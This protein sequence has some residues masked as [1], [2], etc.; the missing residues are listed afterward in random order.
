MT[1]QPTDPKSTE[2]SPQ[3]NQVFRY[4]AAIAQVRATA[5]VAQLSFGQ[6]G[7]PGAPPDALQD[8]VVS[9]P[10]PLAKVLHQVLGKI[11]EAYEKQEGTISVPNSIAAT[12]A[13]Q[14]R[15]AEEAQHPK[16][17]G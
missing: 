6:P 1:S 15:Q 4:T 9:V 14:F 8:L 17:G 13:A 7:A 5:W 12:L 10:W 2:T 3:E 11:L 16:A